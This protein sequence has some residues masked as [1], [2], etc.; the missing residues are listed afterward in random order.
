[1]RLNN[2]Q[3]NLVIFFSLIVSILI[4]T[5]LWDKITLPLN[6]ITGTTGALTE[7]GYNPN[8]DTIRY[9]LFISFPLI[10]FLFL[11]H[12]LKKKIKIKELFF[13]EH[14][15]VKKNNSIIIVLS[16]IF[17]AFI[18]FEFLSLNLSNYRLDPL[19]DG[20]FLTPAQNYLS[21]NML[22]TSSYSMHGASDILYTVLMWKILGT[23]SI[24][25]SRTFIF[26]IILLVKFLSVA[27]SYQLTKISNLNNG[28]KIL[29]FV[30]LTATFVSMSHYNAPI[31][32][33]YFS[34]RD[35]YIIL[36]LIFFIQ[37]FIYSRFRN[38]FTILICLI[39]T[40]SILLHNDTGFY[41]N[42]LLFFYI[43]YLLVIKKNS[44]VALIFL[45]LIIFWLIAIRLIGFDEF[46]V[47]LDHTKTIIFTADLIHGSK[48]PTP[49]FSIG[50]IEYGTRATRGLLLQLTA[51]LLTLNYLISDEKKIF[52]SKKVLFIFLFLLSFVMYKNA[53]GRSDTNH[54]RMSSDFPI[55]INCFFI[56]NYLFIFFENKIV[57]KKFLSQKVFFS[58]SIIFFVFFYIINQD[59]YRINNIRN[60]NKNF[61]N[62]IHLDDKNFIDQKTIKL[63]DYYNKIAE[64][65]DCVQIFT[66]DF[67]IP[68]LLRRPSC[69]KYYAPWLASPLAKQKD[70]IKQL[71]IFQPKY[72]LYKSPGTNFDLN[73]EVEPPEMQERLELVNSFILENYT[74][75]DEFDGYSILK[76][77]E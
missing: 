11:N 37:L 63:L 73:Y 26:F 18:I 23:E 66:Y 56:L 33:S 20:E 10:V 55:L 4:S 21:T 44:E 64:K 53:L 13:E 22:W 71:K 12:T 27:L 39:A 72:I 30:I 75:F 24:G 15:E 49:F 52:S 32:Y 36:F 41:L 69:T 19:H 62:Y 54:L 67:A 59:T 28:G 50:E 14:S 60:F 9:I 6:N 40:I 61:T 57:N 17:I 74:D 46:K 29:L 38:F 68:Y 45:S 25:A 76:I 2:L 42:F 16:F 58:L 31:N 43:L 70:Y 51:G 34:Y 65:D 1:M 47:F 35:V 8:N 5:L 48:Y 3:N 77:K 7:I